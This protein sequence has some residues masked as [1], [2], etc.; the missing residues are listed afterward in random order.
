MNDRKSN[1]APMCVLTLVIIYLL[2]DLGVPWLLKVKLHR[3]AMVPTPSTL[4][5]W[6]MALGVIACFIYVTSSDVR[7]RDFLLFFR[8]GG[9]GAG[10]LVRN[11][12][13]VAFPLVVAWTT[14]SLLNP[15]AAAP[16]ELRVQHP[17]SVP[18]KYRTLENPF[19][20]PTTEM[21]AKFKEEKGLDLEGD[22]LA[23]AFEQSCIEEGRILY[24]ATCRVCHGTKADGNGPFSRGYR[25]RP[26]DFTIKDTIATLVESVV[27]WRIK[28]GGSKH[29]GSGLPNESSPWDSAMPAWKKDFT[30]DQI[31]KIIMAEYDT[32][33]VQPRKP[34][35]LEH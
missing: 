34:E 8:P 6:F 25:L 3:E 7:L 33:H 20:N 4:M 28:E 1:L 16:V 10:E 15:G 29:A 21:L 27:F 5:Q 18:E 11:A 9:K 22:A 26:V 19:R 2:L 24:Q 17:S 35:A 31:W 12:I 14:F 13:L 32:A 23:T 30:D